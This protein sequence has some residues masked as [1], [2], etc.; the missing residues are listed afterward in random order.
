MTLQALRRYAIRNGVRV[1]FGDCLVDE[2]GLVKVPSLRG[3]TDFNVQ[4]GLEAAG[5]FI[6]ETAQEPPKLQKLAR[7]EF[8]ALLP[9]E[10]GAKSQDSE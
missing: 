7:A 3:V 10:P 5:Q 6:L 9:K 1:R 2:N 8:E 4:T